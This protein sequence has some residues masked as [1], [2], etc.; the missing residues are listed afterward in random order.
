MPVATE[1]ANR[2]DE[3]VIRKEFNVNEAISAIQFYWN[4]ARQRGETIVVEIWKQTTD[5]REDGG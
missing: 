1:Q 3:I 2:L 5:P 4:L